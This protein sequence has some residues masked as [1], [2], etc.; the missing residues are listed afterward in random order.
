[1]RDLLDHPDYIELAL[2]RFA[3]MKVDLMGAPA[4]VGDVNYRDNSEVAA[5][6]DLIE[7]APF[8]RDVHDCGIA[9]NRLFRNGEPPLPDHGRV[10][11]RGRKRPFDRVPVHRRQG[12]AL[13]GRRP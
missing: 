5:E 13:T 9:R 10:R 11:G 1:M 12:S 7:G 6:C 3:R 2:P 8:A 4:A